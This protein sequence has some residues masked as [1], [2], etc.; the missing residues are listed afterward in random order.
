MLKVVG[1]MI[2]F[3]VGYGL[4]LISFKLWFSNCIDIAIYLYQVAIYW[5]ADI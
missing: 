3:V 4:A 2:V 5:D 1:Y